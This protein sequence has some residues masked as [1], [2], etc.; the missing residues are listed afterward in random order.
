MTEK[1]L[2]E[3]LKIK[4]E[5]A[6]A[7]E[8]KAEAEVS[9]T[10]TVEEIVIERDDRVFTATYT[11]TGRRK[12]AVAR[13]ILTPGSG[14]VTINKRPADV[15]SPGASFD[16]PFEATNLAGKFDV[17]AN[18]KG[19]GMTGQVGAI[20]HGISR[21]LSLIDDNARKQLKAAGLLTRDARVKERKKYGQRGARARFQFSKR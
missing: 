12:Q 18:V 16:K 2:N 13:I 5:E 9:Q 3:E 14:K 21:A 8:A 6:K 17:K 11:G 4:A 1:T 19:G 15:Y 20:V 7:E 10:E